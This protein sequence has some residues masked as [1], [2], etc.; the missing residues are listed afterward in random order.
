MGVQLCCAPF[1]DKL[2]QH[3]KPGVSF[4]KAGNT[5]LYL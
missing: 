5:G 3:G 2:E 1:K 4:G